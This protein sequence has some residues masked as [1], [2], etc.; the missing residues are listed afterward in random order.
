MPGSFQNGDLKPP[1]DL[2]RTGV[3]QRFDVVVRDT[4]EAEPVSDTIHVTQKP[5]KAVGERAVEVENDKRVG[6]RIRRSYS[7]ASLVPRFLLP[8]PS[9]FASTGARNLP[10]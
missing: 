2:A 7:A 3:A 6:H 5:R 9:A 1:E 4:A 8:P 10:V